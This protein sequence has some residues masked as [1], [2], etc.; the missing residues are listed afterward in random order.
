[1]IFSGSLVREF[2]NDAFV[3]RLV[4]KYVHSFFYL[5][6]NITIFICIYIYIQYIWMCLFEY[7]ILII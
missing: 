4:Q 1:M 5:F 6:K 2:K 7:N 3:S